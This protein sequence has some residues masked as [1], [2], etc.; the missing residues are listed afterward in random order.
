MGHQKK[1]LN[2][3][4][5]SIVQNSIIK[6]KI[7]LFYKNKISHYILKIIDQCNNTIK[8]SKKF[9]EAISINFKNNH[10]LIIE[11]E[12]SETINISKFNEIIITIYKYIKIFKIQ[13]ISI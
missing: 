1:P 11:I 10:Y 13:N 4:H 9:N 7:F 3:M 8:L 6:T 12:K 5:I 2:K